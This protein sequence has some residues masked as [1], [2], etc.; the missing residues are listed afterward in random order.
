MFKKL[1]LALLTVPTLAFGAGTETNHVWIPFGSGGTLEQTCRA[2]F[3]FYDKYYRTETII[4]V[5]PG[6]NTVIAINDMLAATKTPNRVM[7]STSSMAIYNELIYKDVD[8]KTKQM[9]VILMTFDQS[10]TWFVPTTNKAGLSFNDQVAYWK[11]LNRPINVG[12]NFATAETLA[13]HLATIPGLKINPV[14]FKTAAQMYPALKDGSLDLAIT[15][16]NGNEL[17]E[18]GVFRM[19]GYSADFTWLGAPK[20][21]KNFAAEDPALGK[22]TAWLSITVPT[23]TSEQYKQQLVDRIK[24]IYG[25]PEFKQ[26]APSGFNIRLLS[27]RALQD[28]I[29]KEYNIVQGLWK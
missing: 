20:G 7:C 12:F 3:N 16:H 18:Q 28:E 14:P 1:L 22:I 17:A 29:K 21:I 10:L 26:N 23:G 25:L 2:T 19:I 8:F 13:K 27:G 4:N 11:S 6:G 15:A 5:K 24:F 9:E